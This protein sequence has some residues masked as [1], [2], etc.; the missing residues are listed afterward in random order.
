MNRPSSVTAAFVVIL[1]AGALSACKL[2]LPGSKPKAPTGQV[3]A[4]VGDQE[5]T[6]RDLSAEMNSAQISD[7]KVMKQAQQAALRNIVG[8]TVLAKA[9]IDQGIDKTPDFAIAK[10]RLVD[11]L[12]VQSLQNKIAAQAPP[13][14][15]DEADRFVVAHPDLFSAR[16][17]F[18]IDYIRMPRPADPAIVKALE[19]LK[20]LEQVDAQLTAE[21]IPHQRA[22]GNLDSLGADPHMIEAL[23]KL[24][25]GELF[26]LPVGNALLVNQIKDTK[27]VPFEGP[28]ASDFA[29]KYLAKQRVQEAVNREF[30]AIITKAAPSVRF[31]KDFAPA[32]PAPKTTAAP[33]AG[34][35]APAS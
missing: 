5:I 6:M 15:K 28:Q 26:V 22:T 34:A 31:N 14:T 27:I 33:S 17:I 8:R 16:K 9:A 4:T 24:P 12:L 35:A 11:G 3:A 20:T 25:A 23:I 2:E 19:P 13:V 10:K 30:N 1:T 18:A 29:Q 32:A 7:P 21:K